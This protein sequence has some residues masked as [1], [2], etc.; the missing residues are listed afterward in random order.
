M[1]RSRKFNKYYF[2]FRVAFAK[3]SSRFRRLQPF[4]GDDVGSRPERDP[5]FRVVAASSG[6]A[7]AFT[8][9][10]SS[11][12]QLGRSAADGWNQNDSFSVPS[13][14]LIRKFILHIFVKVILDLVKF[15]YH[16]C[17]VMINCG[18]FLLFKIHIYMNQTFVTYFDSFFFRFRLWW[19]RQRLHQFFC[20]R[21]H[22][23]QAEIARWHR[24]QLRLRYPDQVE[25]VERGSKDFETGSSDFEAGSTGFKIGSTGFG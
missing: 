4:A 7:P 15:N 6:R 11:L 22:L 23:D 3:T 20:V 19:E 13:E 8:G 24:S 12:L 14:R 2:C 9:S 25:K 21:R 10:G 18:H 16:F 5:D 1:F 17:M